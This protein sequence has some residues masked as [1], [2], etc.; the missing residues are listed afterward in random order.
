MNKFGTRLKTEP[1]TSKQNNAVA[2]NIARL[3]VEIEAAR[4]GNTN[5]SS[6]RD[7]RQQQQ[8]DISYAEPA[9]Q[10]EADKDSSIR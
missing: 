9:G 8:T 6:L 7:R 4:G 10:A 2:T 5:E 1:I 3:N